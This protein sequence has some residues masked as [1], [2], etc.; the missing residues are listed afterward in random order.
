[1][2]EAVP[3]NGRVLSFQP[4]EKGVQV[5]FGDGTQDA[6]Y[7]LAANFL[8]ANEF[9]R[10]SGNVASSIWGRGSLVGRAV[11]GGFV[12]RAVYAVTTASV[13]PGIELRIESNMSGWGGSLLGVAR[14]HIQRRAVI[15]RL[16]A[17]LGSLSAPTPPNPAPATQTS[18]PAS[19]L[20]RLRDLRDR[21][22][23]TDEEYTA[24]RA[25]VVSRL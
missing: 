2:P 7:W 5:V 20:V 23:I 14:E 6:V 13:T 19:A 3:F 4:T 10:E 16:Q 8:T 18:D 25:E 15:S 22:L 1:V 12:R 17:Y 21:D 24:K 11:A 9:T